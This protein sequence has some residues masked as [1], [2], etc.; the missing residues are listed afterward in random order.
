MASKGEA[1]AGTATNLKEGEIK[2]ETIDNFAPQMNEGREPGLNPSVIQPTAD[3]V[4]R[5]EK[6]VRASLLFLNKA[7]S[8]VA[9]H[10]IM[11]PEFKHWQDQIKQILD[12]IERP[13]VL[14]GVLGYTGSGKSSLINALIDEEMVV[15]A[16][17][18]RASTSV[19]T[20]ISWNDSDDP[21]KAFRAEI[22][23]I[24]EKEWKAEMDILLDDL[25]NATKGEDVSI[26][27]GSEASTAFTKISAVWPGVTLDKLKGMT[28]EEL[29][30]EIEGVSNHL[31]CNL[32]ISDTS[33]K[34][35]SYW[36]LVR[37]VRIYTKAEIL[38]HGL[39]LVD[40]PGLGDSNTG[41]TQVAKKYVKNL[42]YVWVVADIVRAIDDQVAKDLMGKSFRRQLLMDGKYDD[43]AILRKRKHTEDD[44]TD[45][46][47]EN[48][49]Q[50]SAD[51]E[52]PEKHI[53][54]R[55]H[56]VKKR[57]HSVKPVRAL[58]KKLAEMKRTLKLIRNDIKA[59]CTQAQNRYTQEHLK[60]DFENRLRDLEQDI[61]HDNTDKR[62][63]GN[64]DAEENKN[65]V[66]HQGLANQLHVFCVSSKGY[67]KLAGRFKRD[68]IPEGFA[69]VDDTFIP[70]LQQY[71]AASTLTA[72]TKIADT[73][74]NDFNLLK[75]S[76]K[77]WAENGSPNSLSSS[78]KHKLQAML[79]Q[80]LGI[81]NKSF[82]CAFET[83]TFRIREIINTDILPTLKD[84]IET[85][86]IKARQICRDLTESDTSFQT[87]KAICRR[88]GKFNNKKKVNYDWNGVL[89][90][91]FL[92]CLANPWDRVFN[93]QMRHIHDEY[94]RTIV[95]AINTF[96]TDI[97]PLLHDISEA[98][99]S[100]LPVEILAKIPYLQ[101]KTTTK[102]SA[103]MDFTQSQAQE[104]HRLIE[105]LIQQHMRPAY[106]SCSLESNTGA[107]ARM[108]EHLLR[109]IRTSNENMYKEASKLLKKRL[110]KM[111]KT[112]EGLLS[113]T[114]ID[115]SKNLRKEIEDMIMV[116]VGKDDEAREKVS[117]VRNTLCNDLILEL[118]TL[119]TAWV[120]S[121]SEPVENPMSLNTDGKVE[122]DSGEDGEGD[123]F[124]C[125]TDCSDG[126]EGVEST[127][128]EVEGS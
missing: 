33:S 13:R 43:K 49:E 113:K 66:H 53:L 118:N 126:S 125:D 37:C 86:T 11:F 4:T 24:S 103:S 15:P 88:Q 32:D 102:I 17:A 112:L 106:Q 35:I 72:R 5:K 110:N 76:V 77:S 58:E 55:K 27:T 121:A 91:P 69:S 61:S 111:T 116:A 20:E 18:M 98:S 128:D 45:L 21:E 105:P 48:E 82:G 39:V 74:L 60:M 65:S 57:A 100:N 120:R 89:L 84:C 117:R 38:R 81:L 108:K 52:T 97:R 63:S 41:R 42:T 93:V 92:E 85:S 25:K 51:L 64:E 40:L 122:D 22:E 94:S 87:W 28:S 79:E 80:Q 9:S 56:L 12:S 62:Q 29:F 90:E 19:V 101:R 67:Q 83:T 14:V 123:D 109:H 47:P 44:T 114:H 78:Q 34:G 75:L 124:T 99:A 96:S 30:Q 10:T 115:T 50:S 23:F 71:A 16:N 36:P 68:R 59:A 73:F 107:L 46:L 3:A 104:I 70:G 54:E 119:E 6:A 7:E 1:D 127:S 95:A 8:I 26:N 2:T 31:D